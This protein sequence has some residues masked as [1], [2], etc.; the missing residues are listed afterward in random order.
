MLRPRVVLWW[1]IGLTVASTV[2]NAVVP[3]IVYGAWAGGTGATGFDQGLAVTV[4]TF[5]QVVTGAMPVLGPA[6]IAAAI[7]M[8]YVGRLVVRSPE[9]AFRLGPHGDGVSGQDGRPGPAGQDESRRDV[10]R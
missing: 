1:G 7:V 9:H 4:Q 6:L 10:T 3:A 2:I 5:L 8:A